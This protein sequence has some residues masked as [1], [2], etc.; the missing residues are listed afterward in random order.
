MRRRE[1]IAAGLTAGAATA[2]WPL[3]ARAQQPA[4]PVIGFLM[5]RARETSEYLIAAFRQGLREVGYVEGQNVAIEYRYAEGHPER[6]ASLATDLVQRRVAAIV[7]SPVADQVAKAATAAIPIVFVSGGDP[8][9]LGLVASLNHPGGN[10]TGVTTFAF[11]LEAKRIGLLDELVPQAA[12]IAAL[13]DSNRPGAALVIQ[14][15]QAAGRSIGVPIRFVNAASESGIDAAFA[16]FE[17]EK[18]AALSVTASSYFNDRQDQL[19]ALAAQHRIPAIY[20]IGAFARAGG[21]MSYA[22]SVTESY[23]QVGV[24]TGRVLKGDKPADLPVQQPTR[25]E[26]VINLKTANALGLT[27]PETLLATA[28]EL[29][30]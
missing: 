26:L 7:T 20:E 23:R 30:K 19:V 22:P 14:D 25:F 18:I 8:V 17:R 21:L 27:I 3:A 9:Q 11:A 28:D 6:L 15:V 2:A 1:F 10:A 4:V 5:I 16:I 24:Y 12:S 13:M 29:I